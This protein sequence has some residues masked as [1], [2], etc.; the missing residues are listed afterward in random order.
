[1]HKLLYHAK[2]GITGEKALVL[3]M[4]FGVSI[5]H[6]RL[7]DGVCG[8][9]GAAGWLSSAALLGAVPRLYPTEDDGRMTDPMRGETLNGA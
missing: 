3:A 7:A 6:H 9:D 2:L 1:M 8:I 4:S 5:R